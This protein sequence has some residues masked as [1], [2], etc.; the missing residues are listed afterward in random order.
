MIIAFQDIYVDREPMTNL[1]DYKELYATVK[2]S[3]S[4]SVFEN[5]SQYAKK[6]SNMT[7]IHF[8]CD[9]CEIPHV[10]IFILPSKDIQKSDA[11]YMKSAILFA[12]SQNHANPRNKVHNKILYYKWSMDDREQLKR[13]VLSFGYGRW[14]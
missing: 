9:S 3:N 1:K 13:L 4:L 7:Q 2:R 5:Y 8:P 11:L 6:L 10:Y 12:P 14:K